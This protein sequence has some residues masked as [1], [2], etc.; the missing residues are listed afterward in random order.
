MTNF[1]PD[2]S[3]LDL[4]SMIVADSKSLSSN[5]ISTISAFKANFLNDSDALTA[6]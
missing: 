5:S 1:P 2:L 3:S 4:I 6:L